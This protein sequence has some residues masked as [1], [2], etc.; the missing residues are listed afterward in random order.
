VIGS[1]GSVVPLF[2]EQIRKGGPVTVT[3]PDMRRYFMAVSE[4]VLLV[5]EAATGGVG[6][7]TFVLDMGEPIKIIDLAKEMII[8][9]G[10]QPDVDIPIVFSGLRPGEK[11]F[12][13]ILGAKEETEKT[14]FEKI[15]KAKNKYIG[16]E[17]EIMNEVANL[18]EST[19]RPFSQDDQRRML[20]VIVPTYVYD[21]NNRVNG[22]W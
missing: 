11:I 7:E 14:K 2:Q 8:M 20:S 15:Y 22:K 21:V 19:E 5:L 18:I 17:F 9:S 13:D 12:E 16:N 4:A 3:H 6:G 10:K 1:R